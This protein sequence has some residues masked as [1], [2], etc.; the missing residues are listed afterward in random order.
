MVPSTLVRSLELYQ[1]PKALNLRSRV[2]FQTTS[3]S[4]FNPTVSQSI[5]ERSA[6][7]SFKETQPLLVVTSIIESMDPIAKAISDTQCS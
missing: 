1:E 3:L 7:K 2:S 5:S 6:F 4:P